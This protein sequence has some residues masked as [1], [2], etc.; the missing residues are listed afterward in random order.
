VSGFDTRM[1]AVALPKREAVSPAT[2]R[3]V[4]VVSESGSVISRV[5]R[6]RASVST[7][8]SQK[9]SGRKSV[10]ALTSPPPPPSSAPLGVSTR[11]LM[12]RCRL[13]SFMTCSAFCT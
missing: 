1:L 4:Y 11:R 6:P 12:M 10:R 5:A 9:A 2:A 7:D 8:P 13:S 3:I